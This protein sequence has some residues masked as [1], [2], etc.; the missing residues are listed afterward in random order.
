MARTRP[1]GLPL[2]PDDEALVLQELAEID[3]RGRI[4]LLPRW[5]GHVRWLKFPITDQID[6]LM[7]L[8]EPGRLSL[9]SWEPAGPAI[10]ARY[11]QLAQAADET[12]DADLEALRVIQDRYRRLSI[13]K[14]HRPALGDAALHHIGLSLKHG[15][16]TNAWVV[17]S[18][19]RIDI[20]G[21]TYRDSKN[22]G[23][24]PAL[25]DLP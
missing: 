21:S 5:A 20:L 8:E 3:R 22:S 19:T 4:D 9:R 12:D 15:L 16:T 1:S 7:I 24:H 25:D 10:Q 18:P 13:P 6:A 17:V 23:G 14:D 2:V 11:K